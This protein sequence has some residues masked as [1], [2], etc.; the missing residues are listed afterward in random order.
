M[1]GDKKQGR[2]ANGRFEQQGRDWDM[3]RDWYIAGEIT[4]TGPDGAIRRRH[5]AY[6]DIAARFNVS[7]AAVGYH[8]RKGNWAELRE[9]FEAARE[10]E[11][12]REAGRL[13]A[14]SLKEAGGM[15]DEWLVRFRQDLRGGK[16]P[17][18]NVMDLDRAIRCKAF[19]E[20][21]L[22]KPRADSG[23]DQAFSLADLQKRHAVFVQ[24]EGDGENDSRLSG[25]L[26][27]VE[28]VPGAKVLRE[29]LA[30]H[31]NGD[32]HPELELV[33]QALIKDQAG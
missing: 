15:L 26:E 30:E 13:A 4:D 3:A 33:R 16:V 21:E 28:G 29:Q 9:K 27:P 25:Y 6:K 23:R 17:T 24:D 7:T 11:I 1:G 8:A 32:L 10:E 20:G 14:L 22:L 31:E 19:V 5:V 12:A 18:R 2:S